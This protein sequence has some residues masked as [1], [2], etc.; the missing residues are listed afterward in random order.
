MIEGSDNYPDT[1]GSDE[2]FRKRLDD[3]ES[4][5]VVLQILTVFLGGPATE[6]A[7]KIQNVELLRKEV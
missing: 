1:G 5:I 2:S 3:H 6:K 4:K 7:V